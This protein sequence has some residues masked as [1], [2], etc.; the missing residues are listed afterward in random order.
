MAEDFIA[1]LEGFVSEDRKALFKEVLNN[2]T[3]HFT[4]VLEDLFQKHN[5]SAVIRSADVFGVQD[6]H[7]IENNYNNFISRRV[8]KGAQKWMTF[9]NFSK[10][11]ADN[12]QACI[13]RLKEEGYQIVVTS[14]HAKAS[15][16]KEFD[17]SKKS[18]FVLG[19]EKMGVSKQMMDQADAYLKIPMYGF[20]ESLNVSVAGAII[21][22]EMTNRVRKTAVNWN[23]SEEEHQDLYMKWLK[24]SIK[25][26][27][28]IERRF[29]EQNST[30]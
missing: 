19:V 14:P 8:A 2:R 7:V 13:D 5:V 29:L 12:T 1:Y 22:E 16:L 20:T 15:N 24:T 21:L 10:V 6:V 26:Y 18:A 17:V 30:S 9:H 3:R 27:P 25:S 4:I 28:E 23:L 11:G